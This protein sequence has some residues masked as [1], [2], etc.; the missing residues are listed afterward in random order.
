MRY[1]LGLEVLYFPTGIMLTQQKCASDL[2]AM[3]GLSDGKVLY[4]PVEIN[5]KYKKANGEPFSDPPLY[6]QLMKSLVYLTMTS[7]NI[8]YA[9]K[10][11]L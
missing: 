9:I 5:M 10:I 3:V 2:V 4:T 1:F 11:L 7:P 8:S 6:R